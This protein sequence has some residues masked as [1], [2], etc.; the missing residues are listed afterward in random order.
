LGSVNVSILD[1]DAKYNYKDQY[2]QFKLFVN[3]IGKTR[4]RFFSAF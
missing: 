4:K 3:A 1:K 2:E